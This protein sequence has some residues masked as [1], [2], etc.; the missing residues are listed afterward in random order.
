MMADD[1]KPLTIDSFFRYCSEER[2]MSAKC[3]QCD[4][5]WMPPREI[6]PA[7]LSEDMRWMELKGTGELL[8]YTVV[9]VPS[10]LFE[11]KAPYMLGIVKLAEGVALSGLI[12]ETPEEKLRVGLAVK[13]KFEQVHAEKWQP[14]S[15]YYFVP[16]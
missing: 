10:P 11:G 14:K 16:A 15:R 6:C 1:M 5:V 12:R 9:H 2:L 8:T 3:E 4:S 7:C 13:V